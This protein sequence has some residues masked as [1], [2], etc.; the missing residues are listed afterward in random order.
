MMRNV[1]RYQWRCMLEQ[2]LVVLGIIAA[3]A[4][5]TFVSISPFAQ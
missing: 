5:V 1:P 3:L 2:L 4:T